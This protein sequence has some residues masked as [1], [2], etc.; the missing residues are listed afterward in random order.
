MSENWIADRMQLIDA[1]GIRKVFDLAANMENPINLSIGQPHYDTPES[2]KDAFCDAVRE[3]KNAY[4]QSQGIAPLIDKIQSGGINPVSL[5]MG[6]APMKQKS[7]FRL[8]EYL[9]ELAEDED[10]KYVVFDLSDAALAINSAQLDEFTR[11]MEKLTASGK[12]TIAWLENADNT[13]LA[14]AACCKKVF[15]ADFG[16]LDISSAAME[17]M[18]YRDAMDLVGVKASVVR[19]GD[20]KGA[21]EPYTNSEMS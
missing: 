17:T 4:S 2:V 9:Q 12:K 14:V 10:L 11:R 18:Y 16:G 7:F 1:S 5:L 21:V 13:H 6:N 3:G 20:F 8:C 15:M 19:A